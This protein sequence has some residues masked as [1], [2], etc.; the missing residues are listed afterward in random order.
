MTD[1]PTPSCAALDPLVTR[2]IDG[3]LPA[4][5][6]QFVDD[7]LRR[8]GSCH[9]RV[10]A[11][12]AARDLVHA[13]RPALTEGHA[14]VALELKCR[15]L[16][17]SAATHGP[18]VGREPQRQDVR[19]AS[20]AAAR[21][22][23]WWSRRLPMGRPALAASLVLIVG[24][25]L[26]ALLYEATDR[27]ARVLAAELA[28]D[29]VKC[30]MIDDL[31]GTRHTPTAVEQS[32]LSGFGWRLRL[33]EEFDRE[34]LELVGARPCLYAEGKIAHLMYRYQGRPVSI[35]MLPRSERP[36]TFVDVLGHQASVW[37]SGDRTFVLVERGSR[38]EVQRMASL[39][40]A[41][42]H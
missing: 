34:G 13:R 26:L 42:L 8:C 10:V 31:L 20:Q 12:R 30:F 9:A 25:A 4:A 37:S 5:D 7:H 18:D 35:F 15:E 1:T 14:P 16:A 29:H 3:E 41:A 28:A 11:E 38:A 40:R 36:E 23:P 32:M 19:R 6:Q 2:C 17:V 39:V 24:A 22:R 21:E 27:S 33:P